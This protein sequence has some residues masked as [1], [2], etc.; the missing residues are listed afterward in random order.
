MRRTII[1]GAALAVLVIAAVAAAATTFNSYTANLTFRPSKAGSV[2]NASPLGFTQTYAI[3]GT[4]TTNGQPN[5]AAPLIDQQILAY[6]IRT[7]G[8]YFPTC[9]SARLAARKSDRFCPRNALVG[10]GVSHALLGAANSPSATG[11]PCNVGIHIWNA[12]A[13]RV[14]FFLYTDPTHG[15]TCGG[16]T[17][18]AA[19]PYPATAQRR[20]KFLLIDTPL[21]PDVSTKAGNLAGVYSAI[22]NETI[23][24]NRL[25]TRVRGK[26]VG[27]FE[28]IACKNGTR[29]WVQTFT[30]ANFPGAA[31]GSTSIQTV[32]GSAK[33]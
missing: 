8:K 2:T 22:I 9:S 10:T 13:G 18:G 14:T 29:P 7:N 32:R 25:T 6:G 19:A 4:G 1:I 3:S 17:T 20:G 21:P 12:G 15:L 27:Y 23:K 24:F 30:A 5:R 28:S 26:T 16:L 11:A 33:C 31:G